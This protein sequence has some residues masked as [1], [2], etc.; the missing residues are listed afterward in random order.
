MKVTVS[1]L[2]LEG[3]LPEGENPLPMFR[4]RRRHRQVGDNGT[5]TP[6]LKRHL[7]E[8]AG[9]TYLPYRMQDRYTRE[10]KPILLKT[11]VLENDRLVAVFLPEYGGRLYSLKD[12]RTNRDM[13]Y[14]NPVF[15]PANLAIRNAW[16]SG[17]MEWNIGQ[18]GHTFTT[19]SPVYAAKLRGEDG[20]EFLRIYEYERCKNIFWHVDFHL[21]PGADKLSIYVR[22]VNDNDVSVP[23]YWWTNIAAP[24]TPASRVFSSTSSVIYID[25]EAKGFGAGELP[26]LQSV[27]GADAS[28]PMQIPFSSEYFYLT[29]EDCQS[30]WEA[31]VYEDGALLYERSTSLLRY[32][33]MFCWGNHAGGRRW[34]D[35]LSKPGE[36]N[37]IE[38]QGGLT[39]TQ[40]H[41]IEMPAATEW[42]FTQLIGMSEADPEQAY[43]EQWENARRYIEDRV[44]QQLS[45]DMVYDIHEKLRAYARIQPAEQLH[46]GSGWGALER[47]RRQKL[48]RRTVPDGFAF[49][50]GSLETAQLPWLS[51]LQGGRLPDCDP[52]SIPV[53]WMVQE[54]WMS[55]LADSLKREEGQ[56]WNAYLHYG[57]MLYEHGQEEEALK[58]WERSLALQPSGWAY[59]NIAV[60]MRE[61][62]DNAMALSYMERAY[63]MENG[64]P[65]RAFAEEYV[66][67]LIRSEQYEKAW[68]VYEALPASFKQSD[69]LRIIVGKAALALH[70][71][72][73][74]ADLFETEFAVIREGEATIVE[75]WY[76]YNAEKLAKERNAAV[77]DEL[78]LEAAAQFPPPAHIDFRIVGG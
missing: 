71:E 25:H 53:S 58:A 49:A 74:L 54:E 47:L 35:F 21:P 73:F 4:N 37:Y 52:D 70:I 6:E 77:T 57:V 19:A 36:G 29:P 32:R 41:G 9:E 11:I 27:P 26:E 55:M 67:L 15:Q 69:R 22:I 24:E 78:I 68:S 28:Y 38:I 33:K 63:G 18:L 40:L 75:L 45:A 7:G 62:G 44:E 56:S 16:F 43:D 31:V 66:D 48:E 30:P 8:H 61:R 60:L 23:M 51:L 10:R 5:L 2:T 76:Q 14:T 46:A 72:D 50:D 64:F 42:E 34:R 65:D 20:N 3:A 39:P 13:L 59:R 1:S 12:K 17:G